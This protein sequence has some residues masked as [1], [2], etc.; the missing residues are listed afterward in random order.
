L[1]L[2]PQSWATLDY[3][4][5]ESPGLRG[6]LSWTATRTGTVHGLVVWFDS[7][8][9]EGVQISNAPDKPALIYS[10]VFFPWEKPVSLAVGDTV[11]V[12]LQAD[13]VGAD[14]IWRWETCARGAGA[15]RPLKAHFQQSTFSGAPLSAKQLRKHAAD[16]VPVLD[17]EGQIDRFLL[18]QIDGQ[19]SQEAV[20]RRAA[21]RFPARFTRWEDALTRIAE[22]SQKY[23]CSRPG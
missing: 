16:Y 10:R 4:T 13:L 1:L 18:A 22:L 9:A 15:T 11:C 23:S 3:A 2:E 5:V 12:A 7:T 14:Y 17:E 19:T 21:E 20:A 6:T 8:L